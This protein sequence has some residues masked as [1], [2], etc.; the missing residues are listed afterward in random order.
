MLF[1]F[2]EFARAH[3]NRP[4]SLHIGQ[5]FTIFSPLISGISEHKLFLAMEQITDLIEVVLVG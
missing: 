2:L 3:G 4:F 1:E 5:L